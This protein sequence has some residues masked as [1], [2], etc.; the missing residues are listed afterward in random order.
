MND[1]LTQDDVTD[2][3]AI[4]DGAP[5]GW[6]EHARGRRD[7]RTTEL[8]DGGAKLIGLGL[9]EECAGHVELTEAGHVELEERGL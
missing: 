5:L 6:N 7:L 9:A 4:R 8:E 1:A 2:M 3:V